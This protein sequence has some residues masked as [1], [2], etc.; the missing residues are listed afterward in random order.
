M[1]E[2][3]KQLGP[4]LFFLVILLAIK[5]SGFAMTKGKK[6]KQGFEN[7]EYDEKG[8][9]YIVFKSRFLAFDRTTK[10][11]LKYIKM[12]DSQNK[13][14]LERW[15]AEK[16][17]SAK[18]I[19][20]PLKN[21]MP[22]SKEKNATIFIR[23]T[24]EAFEKIP[25]RFLPRTEIQNLIVP[26]IKMG[27]VEVQPEDFTTFGEMWAARKLKKETGIDFPSKNERSKDNEE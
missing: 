5:Y 26:L 25:T 19:F 15:I 3:L 2:E 17:N 9:V 11:R 4:L 13:E 20:I 7:I 27:Y 24:S 21:I 8:N 12:T 14:K 18:Y 22:F 16:L 1:Q 6:M 10:Y 23:D